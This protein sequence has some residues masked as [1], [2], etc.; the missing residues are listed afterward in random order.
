MCFFRG[1]IAE[2]LQGLSSQ[3]DE[4][5]NRTESGW[6]A[7]G[8]QNVTGQNVITLFNQNLGSADRILYKFQIVGPLDHV[9]MVEQLANGAGYR[10]YQ[11]Y[12]NAFSLK[13]W[14]A[15][16]NLKALHGTDIIIWHDVIKM[17]DAFLKSAGGSMSDL[18]NLP[19]QFKPLKPWL[20]YIRDYNL[21]QVEAELRKAWGVIGQGRI[22]T[23]DY[24]YKNYL[25]KL[26]NLTEAI[27]PFVSTAKPWTRELHEMWTELFG[28][29][30][31]VLF[32]GYPFNTL[33]AQYSQKYA[34]EV[35]PLIITS[36]DEGRCAGNA[37]ILHDSLVR[38]YHCL[39]RLVRNFDHLCCSLDIFT[40]I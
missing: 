10:V 16:A 13:A 2:I 37:K 6:P 20:V 11:S 29:P 27:I 9:W 24:F 26:A 32:P 34:L 8:F 39:L 23:K 12:N 3:Y 25:T 5:K 22:M 21:T 4:F 1:W 31:P 33:T 7:A 19:A 38:K 15:K 36:A 30:N 14:L 18:N 40:S 28:A 35:K 17:A